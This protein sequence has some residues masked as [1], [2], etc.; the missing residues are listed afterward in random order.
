MTNNKTSK[1][2]NT[3]INSNRLSTIKNTNDIDDE[4]N[5]STLE[6]N[7]R[8][9]ANSNILREYVDD[10]KYKMISR[11]R[12]RH[13]NENNIILQYISNIETFIKGKNSMLLTLSNKKFYRRQN[14]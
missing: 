14:S 8:Y 12:Q 13:E 6:R 9:T 10:K 7:K 4:L 3:K 2:K 5:N 1:I 11:V